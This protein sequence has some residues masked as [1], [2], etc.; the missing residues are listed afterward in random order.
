M[1]KK[2]CIELN[3]TLRNGSLLRGDL[4]TGK[5]LALVR[6]GSMEGPAPTSEQWRAALDDLQNAAVEQG[7]EVTRV[8]GRSLCEAAEK[9]RQ[10][11]GT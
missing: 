1:T 11:R 10:R 9:L 7:Y 3:A 4:G 5:C 6:V 2:A 8:R